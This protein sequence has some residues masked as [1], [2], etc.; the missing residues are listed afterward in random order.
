MRGNV[1][2][3]VRRNGSQAVPVG[4]KCEK[5]KVILV[6]TD[7]FVG[8]NIRVFAD[9]FNY[10]TKTNAFLGVLRILAARGKKKLKRTART[11]AIVILIFILTPSVIY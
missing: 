8:R 6:Q 3:S 5:F 9:F 1:Y 4:G 11:A 7:C 2:Q 10:F